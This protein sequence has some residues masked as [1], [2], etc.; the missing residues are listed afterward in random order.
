[1]NTE[2]IYK[3][4]R[5]RLNVD[6]T[7]STKMNASFEP[8]K[9]SKDV[10]DRRNNRENYNVSD[11]VVTCHHITLVTLLPADNTSLQQ[12]CNAVNRE[13]LNCSSKQ[14][15]TSSKEN[16]QNAMNLPYST[17]LIGVLILILTIAMSLTV[18][19]WP[20]H[21]VILQPEYWYES[22]GIWIF[23]HTMAVAVSDIF[24]RNVIMKSKQ[25]MSIKL[26]MQ[27]F[28]IIAS[29]Y[30]LV[31]VTTYILWVKILQ[32]CHPMPFAGL[33][34]YTLE[35]FVFW[36]T[37][38]WLL[39]PSDVRSG[40]GS[41]YRKKILWFT[42]LMMLRC[43]LATS[44]TKVTILFQFEQDYMQPN[45]LLAGI[46]GVF[47]PLVK[48]FNVWWHRKISFK[49]FGTENEFVGFGSII[50]VGYLH[51]FSLALLLG[52]S[53]INGSTYTK[54]LIMFSDSIFNTW[55]LLSIL[56]LHSKNSD[57]T[58]KLRDNALKCLALKEFL[59]ILVPI[60]YICS[61]IIAYYGPNASIIGNVKN[62]YWQFEKVENLVKKFENVLIL[63]AIES[64]RGLLFGM[65]LWHYYRLNMFAAYCYI[66]RQYGVFILFFGSAVING[67][68]LI[69]YCNS[70]D[71]SDNK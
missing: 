51:S 64:C 68:K 69:S 21:N 28:I 7:G 17:G 15:V 50:V 58:N 32:Y 47:L 23:G 19:L 45:G 55:T 49:V 52:S 9:V 67:V 39:F 33:F 25:I 3:M 24:E 46:L 4:S 54:Y 48:K 59:E 26:L 38:F 37:S 36:P 8:K 14:E 2:E 12:S 70:K 62:D 61:F 13:K 6:S 5:E 57:V 43:L 16:R 34:C 56:R 22:L 18:T 31:Y 65:I 63:L 1:M 27:H 44:Y 11:L 53:E 42:C 10:F 30:I 41:S 20:Q 40:N 35:Y 29:G 66:V 60:V 71:C